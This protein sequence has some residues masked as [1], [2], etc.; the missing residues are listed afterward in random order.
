MTALNGA[1]ILI[2]GATGTL[3]RA[4]VRTAMTGSGVSRIV[5]FSRDEHKQWELQQDFGPDTRLRFFLGDVRDVTRL[6]RAFA[7]VDVVIHAAALKHVGAVEFNPFEAVKTN[8]VGTQNIIQA[9]LNQNVKRVLAIS[10][11]KASN[12][13]SLY[14]ATKLAADKL[15]VHAMSYAGS[16]DKRFGAIR[17]GNLSGSRG[18]IVPLF[19][20]LAETGELPITDPAMTRFW[21]SVHDAARFILRTVDWM[22][23][24]EIFVP[25]CASARVVDIATAIAPDARHRIVGMRPGEKLHEELLGPQDA[26]RT[27]DLGDYYVISPDHRPTASH[28]GKRVDTDFHYTSDR[29]DQWL[30]VEQIRQILLSS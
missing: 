16:S 26:P 28:G 30:T 15:V 24:G 3:G 10:T 11:D 23:G 18:S 20:K 29:N 4:L 2:T 1:S 12:P 27:E 22:Q 8:I 21:I 25:K 7:G 14:G 17:F 13:V 19:R 9:A 5:I 6:E